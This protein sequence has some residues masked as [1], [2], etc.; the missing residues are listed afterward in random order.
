MEYTVAPLPLLNIVVSACDVGMMA[1]TL[2]PWGD[3]SDTQDGRAKAGING[4]A[5]DVDELLNLLTQDG[6]PPIFLT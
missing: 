2:G 4:D 1:T 5:E 3:N 6:L